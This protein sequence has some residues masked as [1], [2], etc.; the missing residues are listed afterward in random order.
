MMIFTYGEIVVCG[1]GVW[2]VYGNLPV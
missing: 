2:L 1:E